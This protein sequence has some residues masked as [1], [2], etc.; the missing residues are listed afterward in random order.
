MKLQHYKVEGCGRFP[1][2][3]LR[4]DQAWPQGVFDSEQIEAGYKINKPYTVNLSRVKYYTDD[5]INENRWQSF[6]WKIIH[7]Y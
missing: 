5:K 7:Y 6:G 2:D 3:M 4:Y 1:I